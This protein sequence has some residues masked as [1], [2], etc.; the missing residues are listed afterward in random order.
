MV[1]L[2]KRG[3][4]SL[5]S[6][7]SSSRFVHRFPCLSNR[8]K[9]LPPRFDHRWATWK[10]R[11]YIYIFPRKACNNNNNNNNRRKIEEYPRGEWKKEIRELEEM[12]RRRRES[13]WREREREKLVS[14][15]GAWA[16]RVPSSSSSMQ[17]RRAD[18][19]QAPGL[20]PTDRS[21]IIQLASSLIPFIR[22]KWRRWEGGKRE[23]EREREAVPDP[24][25]EERALAP[26]ESASTRHPLLFLSSCLLYYTYYTFNFS[27]T[28]NRL[29]YYSLD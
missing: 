19:F 22:S 6:P 17:I 27:F 2:I 23:G 9:R 26:L 10:K 29:V 11:I 15:D 13:E 14:Y 18:T 12:E 4:Q 16:H 20:A 25:I 24:G 5:P 21:D 7:S 28:L 8:K 1:R 3:G